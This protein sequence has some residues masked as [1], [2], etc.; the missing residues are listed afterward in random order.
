[1]SL[2]L[3]PT[4][5]KDDDPEDPPR[6]D[7]SPPAP[8][9]LSPEP[10]TASD[11][12]RTPDERGPRPIDVGDRIEGNIG[13][14]GVDADIAHEGIKDQS[15]TFRVEATSESQLRPM[16]SVL[17]PGSGPRDTWEQVGARRATADEPSVAL[18][19]TLQSR[20]A[21]GWWPSTT[22]ETSST[23]MRT[24]RRSAERPSGTG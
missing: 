8:S 9:S 11:D 1:L 24:R 13:F 12:A 22:R 6:L 10:D 4:A 7:P 15:V 23:P 20:P 5:C 2:L 18:T 21:R 16:I 19:V 14:P 3:T 17:I